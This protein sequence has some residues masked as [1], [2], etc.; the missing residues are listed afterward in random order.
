MRNTELSV[1]V[2]RSRNGRVLRLY[3]TSHYFSNEDTDNYLVEV[4]P[5]N[6]EK[7]VVFHVNKKFNLVLNS[8]NLQYKKAI[9]NDQLI[10]IPDGIYEFKMS[11]RPNVSTV[12]H[13]YHLRTVSIMNKIIVQKTKLLSDTCLLN[14]REFVINQDKLRDIEEYV[15]AG[16]YK[17]EEANQK[18]EGIELY[19]WAEKLLEQYTNECQ[20]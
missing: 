1:E 12:H 16:E 5:V 4:L 18:K 3:D 7:W 10:E 19:K 17:V 6:K 20:C 13:F 15:Q 8:S 14:R 2:A 11:Y 9:D